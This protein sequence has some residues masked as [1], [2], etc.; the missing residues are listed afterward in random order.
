M[1]NIDKIVRL[2]TFIII[3]A[4]H[5]LIGKTLLRLYKTPV[6]RWSKECSNAIKNVEKH[7]IHIKKLKQPQ[8][9]LILKT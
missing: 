4:S 2:F 3:D 6:P 7:L 5:K 9:I 1:H 8:T